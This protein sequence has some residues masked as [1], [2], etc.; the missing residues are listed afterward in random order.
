MSWTRESL[1]PGFALIKLAEGRGVREEAPPATAATAPAALEGVWWPCLAGVRSPD[2][3][4]PDCWPALASSTCEGT[5]APILLDC[6]SVLC[7][8]RTRKLTT[9]LFPQG[10][11]EGACRKKFKSMSQ[12]KLREEGHI[13]SYTIP[14][15]PAGQQGA[16]SPPPAYARQRLP[17]AQ[18]IRRPA[19]VRKKSLAKNFS[20]GS[21][22][23]GSRL[24]FSLLGPLHRLNR[25][26]HEPRDGPRPIVFAN[27]EHKVTGSLS[28]LSRGFPEGVPNRF[29]LIPIRN[30]ALT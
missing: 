30:I 29:P 14:F 18:E 2:D 20:L 22:F 12:E 3:R 28:F 15:W 26:S 9:G 1:T 25:L 13:R 7:F 6:P 19:A 16:A 10:T 21:Q 5:E 27:I 24:A 11:R 8:L 4:L 17:L 23:N